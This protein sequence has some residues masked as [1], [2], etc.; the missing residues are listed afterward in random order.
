MW[1]YDGKDEKESRPERYNG[2]LIRREDRADR[3][4]R[5]ISFAAEKGVNPGKGERRVKVGRVFP[6]LR[7]RRKTT[8]IGAACISDGKTEEKDSENRRRD[9]TCGHGL[10]CFAGYK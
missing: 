1:S 6:D 2:F 7:K 4:R 8:G 9:K 10:R 3:R 5:K